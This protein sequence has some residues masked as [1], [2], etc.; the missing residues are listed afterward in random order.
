MILLLESNMEQTKIIGYKSQ[1]WDA[2]TII[3]SQCKKNYGRC[4]LI[5][6]KLQVVFWHPSVYA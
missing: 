5:S 3:L 6:H 4:K 1:S 2:S